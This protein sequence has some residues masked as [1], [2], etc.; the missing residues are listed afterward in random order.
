MI[1]PFQQEN[2]SSNF[3]KPFKSYD[4]ISTC[5]IMFPE[6]KNSSFFA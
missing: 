1:I 6:V 3:I 2:K 4:K 5:Q